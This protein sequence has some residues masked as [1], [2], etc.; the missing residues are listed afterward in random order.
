MVMNEIRIKNTEMGQEAKR[1]QNPS[2]LYHLADPPAG[3]F[4]QPAE[5]PAREKV[6][7]EGGGKKVQSGDSC[8]WSQALLRGDSHSR[9]PY[10]QTRTLQR[11][12]ESRPPAPPP[13]RT[14]ELGPEI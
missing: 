8:K 12:Q 11:S 6:E 10:N 9:H 3:N 13:P 2:Y 7:G 4:P 1:N 14:Q 5:W